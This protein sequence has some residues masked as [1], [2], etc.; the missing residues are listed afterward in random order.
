MNLQNRLTI[1]AFFTVSLLYIGWR[2]NGKYA[3]FNPLPDGR[4]DVAMILRDY[5]DEGY[6]LAVTEAG[7]LSLYSEWK[8]IDMW[9]LNDQWIAHNGEITVSY[10]E[11][12]Q[13]DIIMFA[14][15]FTPIVPIDIINP[16][17][18]NSML[19]VVRS[20]VDEHDYC[21]I[22]AFREFP[23]GAHHYYIHADLASKHPELVRRIRD[24][25][26]YGGYYSILGKREI[27]Y[28]PFAP[29]ACDEKP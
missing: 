7:L 4:Y 21:L 3:A 12:H 14:G 18:W 5:R 24:V 23:H 25:H 26:Y 16:S 17:A 2:Q 19:D 9:G 11:S 29:D 10:L 13:P 8:T 15:D 27:D 28:A 6:T 22:S 20:Y 1:I